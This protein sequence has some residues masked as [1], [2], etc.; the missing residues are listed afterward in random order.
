[1]IRIIK[2]V[3][4]EPTIPD[5]V[6]A[7][8]FSVAG[9]TWVAEVLPILQVAATVVAIVAGLYSIAWHRRRLT[10]SDE[11]KSKNKG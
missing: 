10:D 1:M 9:F 3:F 6:V 8:S 4:A 2:A 5:K 11:K 7:S